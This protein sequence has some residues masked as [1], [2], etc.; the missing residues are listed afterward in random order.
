MLFLSSMLRNMNRGMADRRDLIQNGNPV[1]AL[2][3]L[4]SPTILMSLV[5][6]MITL[7]DGLFLNNTSS[8]ATAGAIGFGISI[9]NIVNALS[10]GLAVAARSMIGQLYGRNEMAKVKHVSAQTMAYSFFL[11]I[12]LAP[13]L[14]LTAYILS[15]HVDPAVAPPLFNYLSSYAFVIPFL[16]TAAI[17]NALKDA[18]GRPEATFIRMI[19]LFIAK[20]IFNTVFLVFL[21]W[22]EFGAVLSSFCSY[23]LLTVWMVYDLY[24]A[25][26]PERLDIRDIKPD[27]TTLFWYFIL[28]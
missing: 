15:R 4:S 9:I 10:Q 5:A 7:S 25:A 19:L 26:T 13:I 21:R 18:V 3:F 8:N 22:N 17:F 6:A 20:L 23:T 16:F 2:L 12:A 1:K 27:F 28:S 24:I 11:G 14:V